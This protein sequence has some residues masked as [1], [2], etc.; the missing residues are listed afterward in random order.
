MLTVTADDFGIGYDT[1]RG[2]VDAHLAGTVDATSVMVTTGEHLARSLPLLDKAPRLRLGLH[3]MLTSR[4]GMILSAGPSSGLTDRD[5]HCHSL[6]ALYLRCR[7]GRVSRSAVR[8]EVLAQVDRF[9]RQLGR[10]PAHLDAHHH[11]HQLPVVRQVIADLV[12]QRRLPRVVRNTIEPAWCGGIPGDRPRRAIIHHLGAKSR[13]P[14]ASAGAQLTDAFFG[15]LTPAMLSD[16]NPFASY[17]SQCPADGT[18]EMMCHPGYPDESLQ[19][20]DTYTRHRVTELHALL[21]QTN[22]PQS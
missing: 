4:A 21:S 13:R 2:I 14:F 1:S 11:A 6:P 20:R 18:W 16:A 8:D 15:V 10:P 19:N 3:L 12:Q 5:G 17:L 22:R 9:S 7:L